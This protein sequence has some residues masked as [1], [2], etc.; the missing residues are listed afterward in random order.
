MLVPD[1]P[2]AL[3]ERLADEGVPDVFVVWSQ[4]LADLVAGRQLA[5]IPASYSGVNA[6]PPSL[7]SAALVDGTTY[8][9]PRD[10]ATL[11][12]Y[13][14]PAVFDRAETAYPTAAWGWQELAAA[15]EAT[16]DSAFGYYGLVMH[17]EMSRLYPFLL[18][19]ATDNDPWTGADAA[20][21]VDFFAELFDDDWAVE[22]QTFDSSWAGEAFGR[23]R[24]AM[25]IEGPWLVDY[26]A[27]EFPDL[28]YD[29]VELPVGPVGRGTTGFVSCWVIGSHVENIDAALAL[30]G[31]LTA[32]SRAVAAA[33]GI[34]T[35]PPTL[36]QA[37][38]LLAT[39]PE[40]APFV[41]GLGYASPWMGPA[42]FTERVEA[43]NTALRLWLNDEAT[44]PDLLERVASLGAAP[45]P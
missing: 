25:T 39:R 30:I 2:A 12:L 35:L 40:H 4:Q 11:A 45:A 7:A 10:V 32:P 44:T 36:E 24:A 26:L 37:T 21:A 31:E 17:A 14:N 3:Q 38:S 27:A 13:F 22:P 5:P 19:S 1:Y 9:A 42:G 18:Q 23:G 20:T 28:R 43:A 6:L 15:A 8:C 34:G 29:V 16:T 33:S 41:A